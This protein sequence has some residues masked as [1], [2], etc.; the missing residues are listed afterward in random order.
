M[1]NIGTWAFWIFI[2][3]FTFVPFFGFML[4]IVIGFA[5]D[6]IKPTEPRTVE[7]TF[8]SI[9]VIVL[10]SIWLVLALADPWG[11]TVWREYGPR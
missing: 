7:G 4:A 5:K 11:T 8:I 6:L 10:I 1:N 9:F 2:S 3:L